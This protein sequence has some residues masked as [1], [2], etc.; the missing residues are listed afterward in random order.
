[1]GAAIISPYITPARAVASLVSDPKY[2]IP[3]RG[4]INSSHYS[5]NIANYFFLKNL[6]LN[7]GAFVS[8]WL[9]SNHSRKLRKTGGG[10][11]FCA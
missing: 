4:V 2:F 8:L 10:R 9:F 5:A 7:L 11:Y 3:V 1:M 6:L